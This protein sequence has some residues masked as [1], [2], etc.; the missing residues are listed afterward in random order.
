MTWPSGS[1]TTTIRQRDKILVELRGWIHTQLAL[2]PRSPLWFASTGSKQCRSDAVPHGLS[3]PPPSSVGVCTCLIFLALQGQDW[4]YYQYS[5]SARNRGGSRQM[6]VECINGIQFLLLPG[7]SSHLWA[8]RKYSINMCGME[9]IYIHMSHI[10]I[11]G[12]WLNWR[13]LLF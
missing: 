13:E 6:S 8:H 2:S 11:Y 3:L 7:S 10:Y 1:R 12:T 5:P 9:K 4:S